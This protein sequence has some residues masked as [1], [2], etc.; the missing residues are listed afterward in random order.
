[1]LSED[2]TINTTP[3]LRIF[4]D[5]VRCTHGA[6][7]GQLDS[8]AMFYLRARGI[9]EKQAR[10]ILTVAFARDVLDR[11]RVEPLRN[12]LERRLIARLSEA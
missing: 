6:T 7:V 3:E 10:D 5:D 11:V 12:Q 2:A 9:G 8:E 1:V 4:A